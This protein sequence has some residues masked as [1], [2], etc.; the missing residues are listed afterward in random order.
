M[1]VRGRKPAARKRLNGA[2]WSV[3]GGNWKMPMRS[4]MLTVVRRSPLFFL[5]LGTALASATAAAAPEP[6]AW[7]ANPIPLPDTLEGNFAAR[8]PPS[9]AGR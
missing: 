9:A 7:R 3:Y 8:V 5:S 4:L 1:R 2:A 6:A